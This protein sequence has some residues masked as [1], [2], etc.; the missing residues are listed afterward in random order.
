MV[1]VPAR[2][3]LSFPALEGA[4]GAPVMFESTPFVREELKWGIVGVLAG[5]IGYHVIPAQIISLLTEDNSV[6][7][8]ASPFSFVTKPERDDAGV[9]PGVQEPHCSGVPSGRGR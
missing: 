8:R 1:T 6:L 4:S 9:D 2:G 3:G 5:N 7:V